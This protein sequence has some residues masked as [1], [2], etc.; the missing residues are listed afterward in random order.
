MPTLDQKT[1]NL[2][3]EDAIRAVQRYTPDVVSSVVIFTQLLVG[4]VMQLEPGESR[5]DI[6][7]M[8]IEAI[9]QDYDMGECIVVKPEKAN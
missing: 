7:R 9:S 2:A 1:V 3:T 8:I 4:A 5:N 6:R